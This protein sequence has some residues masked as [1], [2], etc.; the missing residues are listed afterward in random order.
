MRC[1][2]PGRLLP[3]W[4]RERKPG[5]CPQIRMLNMSEL[6]DPHPDDEIVEQFCMDRMSGT[7]LEHFETHLL[8]CLKC[9]YRV[10]EADRCILT[11]RNASAELCSSSMVFAANRGRSAFEKNVF[12]SHG[13]PSFS[14]VCTVREL[15]NEL[16]LMP[17]IV[18]E[19]PSFGLSVHE[20]VRDGCASAVPQSS[21]RLRTTNP[22]SETRERV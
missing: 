12:I 4:C 8:L 9:Q 22:F 21:L 20:K 15:L 13:G 2:P 11:I 6:I 19:L 7:A 14:H 17:V 10:D 3:W 1:W 18:Q 5:A 16:G